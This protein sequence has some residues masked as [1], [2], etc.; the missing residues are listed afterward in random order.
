[1]DSKI[2]NPT[3]PVIVFAEGQDKT[4]LPE[5]AGTFQRC[6]GEAGIPGRTAPTQWISLQRIPVCGVSGQV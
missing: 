6:G 3:V 5:S 1:M 4:T 2:G